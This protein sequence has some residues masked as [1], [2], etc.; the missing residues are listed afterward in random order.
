MV[1]PISHSKVICR[2][3]GAVEVLWSVN[4]VDY[5]I[6]LLGNVRESNMYWLKIQQLTVAMTITKG[7]VDPAQHDVR[8]F[9]VKKILDWAVNTDGEVDILVQWRGHDDTNNTWDPLRLMCPPW[10]RAW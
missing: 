4:E 7:L 5:V 1:N 6:R 8:K 3:Q 10:W 2:Y 9:R